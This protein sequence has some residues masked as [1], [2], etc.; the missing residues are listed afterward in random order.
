MADS[1]IFGNSLKS[2]LSMIPKHD[3]ILICCAPTKQFYE[4]NEGQE[5]IVSKDE[6]QLN[7]TR[8]SRLISRNCLTF[9][10]F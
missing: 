9:S 8:F 6:K 3:L 2:I 1:R 4:N 7:V 10:P 5:V